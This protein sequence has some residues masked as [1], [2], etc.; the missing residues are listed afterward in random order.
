MTEA[1][2]LMNVNAIPDN[3]PTAAAIWELVE[4]G[5]RAAILRAGVELRIW[6]KVAG[7]ACTAQ[8]I[9][10]RQGWDPTG[11]RVLLD[12]LCG[13]KLMAREADRY[14]PTPEAAQYLRSDQPT[15]MCDFILTELAWIGPQNLTHAL[16][17]GVRPIGRALTGD[18]M[19]T[20]WLADYAQRRVEPLRGLERLEDLWQQVG[21]QARQGLRVLDVACGTGRKSL[22]LARQHPGVRVTLLDRAPVLEMAQEVAEKLGV[23]G[24]VTAL[25]GDIQRVEYGR[26]A[27]DVIWLG[28]ITHFF[29]PAE[30]IA[31]LSKAHEALVSGGIVVIDTPARRD[32]E[33]MWEA[34]WLYVF[35][36]TGDFYSFSDYQHFLQAAGFVQAVEVSKQLIKAVKP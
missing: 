34:V 25:A 7:G 29:S 20:H 35:C 28:D 9:A 6:D 16:Q 8:E 14:S 11:A 23:R 32:T 13:L 12:A 3:L 21:V 15:S 4:G 1:N 24:Q 5:Q 17:T 22:A 36:A 19:A 27:Y 31:I 30:N 18:D 26:G 33:P 2:D 10:Q